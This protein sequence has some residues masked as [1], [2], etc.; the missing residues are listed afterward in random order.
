VGGL[1]M[2]VLGYLPHEGQKVD[3]E[4]FSVVVKKMQ[5]PRIVL[6]RIYPDGVREA[7]GEPPHAVTRQRDD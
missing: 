3:F 1:I 5:G 6:V 7:R 2:D 4:G